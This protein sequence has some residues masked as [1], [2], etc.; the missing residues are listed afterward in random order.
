MIIVAA[1]GKAGVDDLR[2]AAGGRHAFDTAVAVEKKE[3]AVARPVGSFDAALSLVNC[4]AIGGTDGDYFEGAV[5]S[6]VCP[7][8]VGRS[9][10]LEIGEDSRV[11]KSFVLA[12]HAEADVKGITER[13]ARRTCSEM[14]LAVL[15]SQPHSEII[16]VLFNACPFRRPES[17][18][19]FVR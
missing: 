16:A 11:G 10:D 3:G 14:K 1:A 2:G 13:D 18:L 15:A 4:G 7:I 5:E 9:G 17:G 6:C 12:A 8:R 19:D